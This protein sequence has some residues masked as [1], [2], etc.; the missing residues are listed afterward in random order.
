MWFVFCYVNK[1][2]AVAALAWLFYII[3]IKAISSV[4]KRQRI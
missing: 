4:L 1:C 2:Q 3:G